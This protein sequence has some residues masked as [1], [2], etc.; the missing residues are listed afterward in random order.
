MVYR[1][2]SLALMCTIFVCFTPSLA[3]S[4]DM[5][6]RTTTMVMADGLEWAPIE[7]PGFDTGMQ[8]AGLYGNFAEEGHYALRLS[9]PDG[10]RFPAHFHPMDE[11]LTVLSGTLLLAMGVDEDESQLVAY[12]PGDFMNIPGEHPHYG[13]A[14]GYTVVQL[15]GEGQFAIL[16][17]E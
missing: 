3:S 17:P 9:F 15:H 13:G 8:I 5:D 11:N 14:T 2:A 16:L 4:Q 6:H 10:Y 7:V 1:I 12:G